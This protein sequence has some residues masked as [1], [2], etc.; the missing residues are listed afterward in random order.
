[1]MASVV[2]KGAA[3]HRKGNVG[4]TIGI[5]AGFAGG[6]AAVR[7]KVDNARVH[8]FLKVLEKDSKQVKFIASFM[9]AN[10]M[11]ELA[12]KRVERQ[13]KWPSRPN[14]MPS[15]RLRP[16]LGGDS[17]GIRVIKTI[18]NQAGFA[19]GYTAE[20]TVVFTAAHTHLLEYGVDPHWQ[21]HIK[22]P[23]EVKA[24]NAVLFKSGDLNKNSIP[25]P[26]QML[27]RHPGHEPKPFVMPSHKSALQWIRRKGKD[28]IIAFYNSVVKRASQ[29]TQANVRPRV[30]APVATGI[31][32]TGGHS[33]TVMSKSELAKL[34][35]GGSFSGGSRDD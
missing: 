23:R 12:E 24:R 14:R 2:P 16:G 30:A 5:G 25:K 7:I 32:N 35:G 8:S 11:K 21:T 10:K 27:V 15:Q 9:V 4:T 33:V 19:S 17:D 29:K 22:A 13:S 34:G 18:S 26:E 3:I 20:N 1:M 31:R 6:G 28:D